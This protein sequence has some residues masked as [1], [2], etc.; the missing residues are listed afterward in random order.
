[1][2][3]AILTIIIPAGILPV[4]GGVEGG[5]APRD[6]IIPVV[7]GDGKLEV[8]VDLGKVALFGTVG[9][10]VGADLQAIDLFSGIHQFQVGDRRPAQGVLS[11]FVIIGDGK[12]DQDADDDD[13]DQ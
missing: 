12:T 2:R 13:G 3:H 8:F 7:V 10:I 1:M 9:R 4:R 5:S 6:I 11:S